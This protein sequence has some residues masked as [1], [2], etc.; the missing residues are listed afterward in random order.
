MNQYQRPEKRP[1]SLARRTFLPVLGGIGA[2]AAIFGLLWVV[3]FWVSRHADEVDTKLGDRVFHISVAATANRIAQDGIP[4]AFNDPVQGG[5]DIWVNHVGP[6][7]TTNWY[8]FNIV[9]TG[10]AKRCAVV[11]DN[12]TKVFRD[13]CTNDAY[14]PDGYLP[15]GGGNLL[16]YAVNVKGNDLAIDLQAQPN[17]LD[18]PTTKASR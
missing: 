10:A 7:L 8:A 16:H 17:P 12:P 13:P 9:P 3:A 6:D 4:V 14:A 5:R 2:I 1:D 18:V 11:W 15:G